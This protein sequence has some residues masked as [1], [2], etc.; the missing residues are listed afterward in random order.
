MHFVIRKGLKQIRRRLGSSAWSV[1][2]LIRKE[3]LLF[4][5][6]L[7]SGEIRIVVGP[8]MGPGR[9]KY[10]LWSGRI[11]RFWSRSDSARSGEIWSFRS[12]QIRVFDELRN[13]DKRSAMGA[14][15]FSLG[16]D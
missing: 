9:V 11:R 4:W 10:G 3:F 1:K 2:P 13:P 12:G 5:R 6:G 7:A 14:S 15:G 16:L 8:N